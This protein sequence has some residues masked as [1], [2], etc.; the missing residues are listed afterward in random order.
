MSVFSAAALLF[1]VFDPLGNIPVFTCVL[2]RIEPGRRRRIIVRELLFAFAILVIFLFV[3]RHILSLLGI[4]QSS[5]GIAGGIILLMIAIKMVFSGSEAIF[6]NAPDEEPFLVPL[7]VP[8]IA[9]P[10]AIAT[11]ILLMA[12][13]P[14]RWHHWFLALLSAWFVSGTLLMFSDRLSMFLGTRG[15][16][17]VERLMGMILTA[18]SVEMLIKGI[19]D[20]F[21]S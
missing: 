14:G 13:D 5:L 17:A 8:L 11:V 7:A 15:S 10:S 19:R 6:E 12:K 9:G 16:K 4:S 21:F 18:V 2:S 3:G 1:L 20:S